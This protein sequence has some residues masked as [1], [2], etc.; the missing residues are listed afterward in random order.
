MTQLQ[1]FKR[2]RNQAEKDTRRRRI[3]NAAL[4]LYEDVGL[5]NVRVDA[6]AKQAG[7]A[8]GT[9]YLYFSSR[10][11]IFIELYEEAFADWLI[12]FARLPALSAAD[13]QQKTAAIIAQHFITSERFAALHSAL[14]HSL[15]SKL[16]AQDKADA[17]GVI[18]PGHY[19]LTDFLAR[20]LKLPA[21]RAQEHAH[22]TL[23]VLAGYHQMAVISG[24]NPQ[25]LEDMLSRQL[26]G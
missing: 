11:A 7:I 21:K 14:A 24:P 25:L 17:A 3:L 1:T 26:R 16:S 23:A 2:A 19:A 22:A 15:W 10:E 6:I 13:A 5:D 20:V 4:A 8:K 12:G 18:E 9:V